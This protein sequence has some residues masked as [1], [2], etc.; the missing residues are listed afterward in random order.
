MELPCLS[1]GLSLVSGVAGRA[2]TGMALLGVQAVLLLV[3]VEEPIFSMRPGASGHWD[4]LHLL[5]G[6]EGPDGLWLSHGW[7]GTR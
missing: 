1:W 4:R 7:V 5:L 3:G 2:G 6:G